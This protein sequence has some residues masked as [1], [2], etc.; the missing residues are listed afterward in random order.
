MADLVQLQTW[1]AEAEAARHAIAIG[2][3]VQEVWR[4]GRR[5]TYTARSLKDLDSYVSWLKAEIAK[6]EN[7]AAGRPV[8]SAIGV[9]Y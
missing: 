3:G 5:V 8:R 2:G 7:A 6:L 1:L 4:D 9:T